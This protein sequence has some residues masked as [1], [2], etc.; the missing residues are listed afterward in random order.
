[1]YT[2]L[3]IGSNALRFAM[4]TAGNATNT[5]AQFGTQGAGIYPSGGNSE[6]WNWGRVGTQYGYIDQISM[7]TAT[8][9]DIKSTFIEDYRMRINNIFNLFSFQNAAGNVEYL[10][11]ETGNNRVRMP[12]RFVSEVLKLDNA[13]LL[14]TSITLNNNWFNVFMGDATA[15]TVNNNA[16]STPMSLSLVANTDEININNAVG[17][18]LMIYINFSMLLDKNVSAVEVTFWNMSD[19][20]EINT[21]SYHKRHRVDANYYLNYSCRGYFTPTVAT[22]RVS[23]KI[24]V[25][26]GATVG[27]VLY[28][29]RFQVED[30]MI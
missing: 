24:R 27:G 14:T 13:A 26:Q 16:L 25:N 30:T 12:N 17:I 9:L 10:R 1:M 29:Y 23:I 20:V 8:R 11:V 28:D 4:P 3:G 7:Y 21:G 2:Y 5:T 15:F 18:K 6:R 19:N 22:Q